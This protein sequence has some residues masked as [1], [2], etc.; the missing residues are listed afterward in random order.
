VLSRGTGVDTY[1]GAGLEA[2]LSGVDVVIDTLNIASLRR[3]VAEDF[4]VTTSRR[5]QEVGAAQGVRHL[6]SLSILGLDRVHGYPYYEAKLAQEHEVAMGPVP[7]TVLR[8]AQF[9][10]FPAQLIRQARIGP[11]AVLPRMR[12]QPVAARTVGA[13]LAALAAARPGGVSALAGPEVA[14][15]PDLARRIVA[16]RGERLQVLAV[17]VPGRAFGDMRGNA[18]LA[19]ADTTIDGPVFEEW[20]ASDDAREVPLHRRRPP[21]A[22]RKRGAGSPASLAGPES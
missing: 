13:S 2:A 20:L 15:I 11:V 1:T 9:F 7:V 4:F 22:L 8:A 17:S 10:E 3:S 5:L 18:L 21:A 19:G 12:S 14:D 6:V 16:A